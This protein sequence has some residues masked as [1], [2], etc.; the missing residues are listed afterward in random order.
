LSNES[1]FPAHLRA[2]RAA[3]NG[4]GWIN[5]EKSLEDPVAEFDPAHL[6]RLMVAAFEMLGKLEEEAQE[7]A[8][9]ILK[10]AE[11]LQSGDPEDQDPDPT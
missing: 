1:S 8:R 11:R 6:E 5:S 7:L 4:P 9:A 3:V 2:T 10:A